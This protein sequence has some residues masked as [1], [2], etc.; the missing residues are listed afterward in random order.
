MVIIFLDTVVMGELLPLRKAILIF[1]NELI[2]ALPY[3]NLPF[4]ILLGKPES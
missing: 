2:Y 3:F 1:G 4:V